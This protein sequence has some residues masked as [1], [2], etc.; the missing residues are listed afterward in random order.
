MAG[1]AR[2]VWCPPVAGVARSVRTGGSR[3]GIAQAVDVVAGGSHLADEVGC[4]IGF[5]LFR[6]FFVCLFVC[7][8]VFVAVAVGG[9]GGVVGGGGGVVVGVGVVVVV[10]V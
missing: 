4:S 6:H 10:V 5:F 3:A 8:F 2:S 9:G 7:L 1:V